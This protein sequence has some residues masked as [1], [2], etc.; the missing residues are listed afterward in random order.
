MAEPKGVMVFGESVQGTLA[1]ISGELLG[2][3]KQ[4]AD[5]L[6]EELVCILVGSQLGDAPKN[7]IAAGADKVYTV[8]DAML[9]DYQTDS[10]LMV[11]EKAIKDISPRILLMGQTSIGR[12]LAPRLAF[13]L[14]VGLAM[15]T[16]ELSI[17]P[18]S[19]LL[20]ETRPVYGG[21][22]RAIF[23][24]EAFPQ[25]ATVRSKAMS[26][27]APDASK[28]GEVIPLKVELDPSKIRTKVLQTVKEELAGIK[29]EDAQTIICGGRGIGG[30]E[31]FKQLE[32]LAKV[33]KGAV[34]AS[35]PPC[36][37]GWVPDTT[38]IGLTGKIVAPE[39]YIAVGVSGSSQ[40]LAGCSG[41]KNVVAINK[42]A[43]ANIFKEARFGV[44]GDW[45]QVLPAFAEKVKELLAG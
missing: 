39:L 5:A 22:A 10:Y 26:P 25:I 20:Q 19:R 24:S 36:D 40:H 30:P 1:A 15:D 29:L 32:E 33:L 13:R 35:R 31:G 18:Q 8:E 28:Q 45:K 3:G 17:D 37:N 43:E 27:L 7:A 38:Q 6:K 34:G 41:S 23:V 9:A 16:V 4:L 11:M 44:V 14:G 21:N 2:C 42:D 12:D